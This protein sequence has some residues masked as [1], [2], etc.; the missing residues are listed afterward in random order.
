[1]V[2]LSILLTIFVLFA[3]FMIG[4]LIIQLQKRNRYEKLLDKYRSEYNLSSNFEPD[5]VYSLDDYR[6]RCR[7]RQDDDIIK[8]S[9]THNLVWS[10]ETKEYI[11]T[12]IED[13]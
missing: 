6:D 10:E 8:Y 13:E 2:I 11:K 3:L 9:L 1:M 12:P 4:S 7:V 5:N